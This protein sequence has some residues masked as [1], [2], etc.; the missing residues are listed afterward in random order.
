MIDTPQE[1]PEDPGANG[2]AGGPH[3]PAPPAR[4]D[5]ARRPDERRLPPNR[6]GWKPRNTEPMKQSQIINVLIAADD[7]HYDADEGRYVSLSRDD[8]DAIILQ[9]QELGINDCSQITKTVAWV[10]YVRVGQL[11]ARSFMAG[12]LTI[13]GFAGIEPRFAPRGSVL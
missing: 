13:H 12:R 6:S 1:Q 7:L 9:C 10:G 3:E 8:V 2:D 11:L 5:A 4:E